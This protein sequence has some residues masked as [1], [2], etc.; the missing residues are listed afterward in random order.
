M[1]INRKLASVVVFSLIVVAP[2]LSSA[3]NSGFLDIYSGLGA[4]W[5]FSSYKL[6]SAYNGNWGTITRQSDGATETIGFDSSGKADVNAFNSFC[7]GTNCYVN[8]LNDQVNG[9]NATQPTLSKMPR[10]IVDSN[11]VLAVCP[12]PGTTMTTPYNSIVN[13]PKVHA[14]VV[15]Q[16][17]YIDSRWSQPST[18]SFVISGNVT[19]G[20]NT[21][22]GMS[23]Q[24]GIS[25]KNLFPY[26]SGEPGITDSA[27]YLPTAY[28]SALPTGS[29]ATLS[30]SPG[31]VSATGSKVGDT[32]TINNAVMA[33]AWIVNGPAS[34]AYNTS[35]YWGIGVGATNDE[36]LADW[37]APRNGTIGYVSAFQSVLGNGMRGQW[38]VYDYD[39]NTTQLD[40]DG[41]TL[42]KLVGTSAN[43][44]YSTN[45]G[46][47]LFSD[48]NGSEGTS[49]ACFETMVLFP[50]TESSRVPMAQTLMSQ[51]NIAPLSA[52]ATSDGF[53]MTGEYLPSYTS[54]SANAL[55]SYSVGPDVNGLTWNMQSG[56][57]SWPSI[58]YANN[59]TNNA[60]MW[61]FIVQKG[62]SDINIT[63]AERS[64]IA[65]TTVQAKPGNSFS[66]FYQFDF[67]QL[68]NQ[69]G[70]WCAS[71]QIH[72]NNAL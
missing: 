48:T 18:P 64:E 31:N 45:T 50:N 26:Q 22:S 33:G 27:G 56:G 40:Y 41:L 14:F 68:A 24:A 8:T 16:L 65:E 47:T 60:T 11:N 15:A 58:A 66:F 28:I 3:S 7:A 69:T 17:N 42:G 12:Q 62:D 32:L 1:R 55:G 2:L 29:T 43:I 34:S 57:Y 54:A 23:S 63:G 9:I 38:A 20:S 52:P 35:A 6:S 39:T 10:V 44:T 70:D 53:T 4:T 72:Y 71:G 19:A 61:R 21:I 13:T 46:M 49:N 59:I 51:D 25:T 5:G 30:Y 37:M 36:S 67:E